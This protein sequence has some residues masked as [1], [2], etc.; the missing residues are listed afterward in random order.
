MAQRTHEAAE[1]EKT[2][3]AWNFRS[4]RRPWK[5]EEHQAIKAAQIEKNKQDQLN[6]NWQ[7]RADAEVSKTQGHLEVVEARADM[8]DICIQEISGAGKI[9]YPLYR[10]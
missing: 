1:A 6:W 10:Q 8:E 4:S 7:S 5:F 2:N 3:S 9:M